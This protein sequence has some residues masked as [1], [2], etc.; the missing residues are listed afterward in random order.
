VLACVPAALFAPRAAPCGGPQRPAAAGKVV[1]PPRDGRRPAPCVWAT[2][3]AKGPP[4]ALPRGTTIAGKEVATKDGE[5][6]G[7]LH[8]ED[9]EGLFEAVFFPSSYSR[10]LPTLEGN[11][12]VLM[13]GTAHGEY[14]AVSLHVDEVFGLNRPD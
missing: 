14:G 5:K 10:A 9:E 2:G 13:V 12:A 4:S 3:R 6:H 8:F 1:H 11:R 7:L